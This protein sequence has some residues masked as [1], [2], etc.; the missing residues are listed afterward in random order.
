MLVSRR[1]PAG[2][3]RRALGGDKVQVVSERWRQGGAH[4]G[5]AAATGEAPVEGARW[6]QGAGGGRAVAARSMLVS[7]RR[8]ARRS[9]MVGQQQR[10]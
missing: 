10:A 6:R 7:R 2:R 8:P 4:A 1:R 5:V 9:V 3:R